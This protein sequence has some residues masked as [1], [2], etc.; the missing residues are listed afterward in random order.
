MKNSIDTI[1]NRTCD[2]LA[3]SAVAQPTALPRAPRS[4]FNLGYSYRNQRQVKML[5]A[6]K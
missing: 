4:P 1:R 3:C 6:Y 2:R 5:F